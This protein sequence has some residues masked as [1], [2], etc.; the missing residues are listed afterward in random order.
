MRCKARGAIFLV[1]FSILWVG[2]A[3]ARQI[4]DMA[5]RTVSVPDVIRKVYGSSPPA[6]DM[7]YAID[8]K[9]IAGVNAPLY[10][11]EKE[12]L[13]PSVQKLPVLGGWFGQG[14]TP[15]LETILRVKPDVMVV[16][17][18]SKNAPLNKKIEQ[19]ARELDLPM[20]YSKLDNLRDYPEAFLFLGKLLHREKRAREL[21][22]YASKVLA[23][24]KSI[25][26][27]IPE[28]EK[29]SVYFA[30]GPDGLCTECDKSQHTELIDLA[31]GENIYHCE[32]GSAYGMERISI[33]QVMKA[34]PEV[35]L[36]MD[37]EFVDHVYKDPEWQSIRAVKNKRVYLIPAAPFNWFTRPPSFMRLIGIKWVAHALYPN[38][39]AFDADRETREFYSLFL[40]IHLD[41]K[42][43]REVLWK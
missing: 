19:T 39:F 27:S 40:R 15:D 29:V 8:P 6:T 31:G 3:G 11:V 21:S 24:T 22:D 7:I 18:W 14:R 10:P 35:I 2:H 28:D 37:R 26:S 33:E 16:W 12:F 5:G 13:L 38:R 4:V 43:L 1:L 32:P 17:M 41:D 20:V 34:N 25:A 23:Q 42:T 9:L 36:A 30:E